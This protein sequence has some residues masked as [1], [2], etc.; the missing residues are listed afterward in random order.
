MTP[1]R[2]EAD[3]AQLRAAD[4]Q[5]RA[6]T[7]VT[8]PG[9]ESGASPVADAAP[10]GMAALATT[11]FLFSCVN[12]GAV[13]DSVTSIVSGVALFFG[14]GVQIV[15]GLRALWRGEVFLA[16]AFTSFGA[17]WL[18]FWGL[19]HF[20][21]PGQGATPHAANVAISLFVTGWVVLGVLLSVAALRT[22]AVTAATIIS[23]TTTLA[24]VAV[25]GVV[26]D[27]RMT[28]LAGWFGLVA[29][30]CGWYVTFAGVVNHTWGRAVVP[31][32]PLGR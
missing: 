13:P 3:T 31:T 16:T 32:W 6:A 22:D 28:N 26:G 27:A 20:F 10:I 4:R 25:A 12:V 15:A 19:S 11:L 7:A 14:G 29:A 5:I 23:T 21:T 9:E 18:A 2:S 30:V 17:F 1:L 24:A 8:R